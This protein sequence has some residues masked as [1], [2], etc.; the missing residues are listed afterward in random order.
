[1]SLTPTVLSRISGA[2]PL[3]ELQE[4]LQDTA[5]EYGQ[6]DILVELLQN[7][8]DELDQVRY[9]KL[10]DVAGLLSSATT[11]VERWNAAVTARIRSDH[12]DFVA[13]GSDVLKQATFYKAAS[14]DTARRSA[15]W[16]ALADQ[17]GC[18]ASDLADASSKLKAQLWIRLTI[19]GPSSARECILEVEDSGSGMDK[20]LECFQHRGSSKRTRG[21]KN[22]RRFG[23]RGTHGWGL[24]SILALSNRVEVIAH[25]NGHTIEAYRFLDYAHFKDGHKPHPQNEVIAETEAIGLAPRLKKKTGTLIRVFLPT[26]A[27]ENVFG[28]TVSGFT[29]AKFA[30][31]LRLYTPVGQVNDFVL[32]PA[33]HTLR[34]ADL[35]ITLETDVSGSKE[36]SAIDYDTWRFAE[37]SA[38]SATFDEYIA[39]GSPQSYSVHTVYRAQKGTYY[40]LSGAEI[41][42]KE[43]TDQ[44]RSSLCATNELPGFTNEESKKIFDIPRG[45]FYC[46]SGGMRS[47]LLVRAPKGNTGAIRGFVLSENPY[48]TLGRKHVMD[49]RTAPAKVAQEH[50]TAYDSSV[51]KKVLTG[52][53]VSGLTPASLKWRQEFFAKVIPNQQQEQP[54]SRDLYIWG[55]EHSFE[56]R[57]MLSFAELVARGVFGDFRVIAAHL[58]DVYD[59]AFLQHFKY[60]AKQEMLAPTAVKLFA[61]KWCQKVD[62]TTGLRYGIGEFKYEGADIL[63]E[64]TETDKRKSADTPDLLVCWTFDPDKVDGKGWLTEDVTP[65]TREFLGQTHVWQDKNASRQRVRNLAVVALSDVIAKLVADKKL[66]GPPAPWPDSLPKYYC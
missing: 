40:Y 36:K 55:S 53:A 12:D 62:K 61:D 48:P 11:T 1:M 25:R 35:T 57:V 64:F 58:R 5:K 38:Q 22:T 63:S 20:P 50:E 26:L 39:G 24:S 45:F 10:C 33:Y 46:F 37:H 54:L 32:H 51:R 66:A 56:A 2:D 65:A 23:V 3:E 14:D 49:Q 52:S 59:F 41:Q 47:E 18:G 19:R 9:Q 28:E 4:D 31:L 44:V 15:W 27:D 17:F 21:A 7:A 30:T 43:L 29:A 60:G 42:A 6:L 34:G 13:A 8:L 16:K